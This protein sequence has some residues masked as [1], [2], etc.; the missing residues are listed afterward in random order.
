MQKKPRIIGSRVSFRNKDGHL[1]KD[2]QYPKEI[3]LINRSKYK[4]E[5]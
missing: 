3:V 1:D 2:G 5:V 4:G